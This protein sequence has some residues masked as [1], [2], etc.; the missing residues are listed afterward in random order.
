MMRWLATI[1]IFAI[2]S[3][4]LRAD[5]TVVQKTTVVGGIAAMAGGNASPTL[6]NRLKGM[7]LRTDVQVPATTVS[8]ITDLVAKEV[9]VLR[10]E[11]K[12]AQVTTAPAPTSTT[13]TTDGPAPRVEGSLTAT[14]KS[15]VIDGVKC[16]EYAFS[17]S[18]A[19]AELTGGQ[20]P[21]QAAQMFKDMTVVMKGSMWVA[22]DVPGAAEYVAFQK[23][24]A[25]SDLVSPSMKIAGI[26]VP[27]MDRMMKAMAGLD[28]ISYL[29]VMDIS[30]EGG[31]GQMS[32]LVR[33][34]AA[35]RITTRVTSITTDA[36]SDDLFKVP[37][38]YTI[39]K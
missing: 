1:V 38:G 28:G 33:Q 6:T 19:M 13:T 26:N 3:A 34:M 23:A 35:V 25:R 36:L 37:E 27:G 18:L 17:S 20:L 4:S 31:S 8:T 2:S 15:Q 22:R 21:P 7:K 30:M 39:T 14:G 10:A 24:M 16:E 12:I 11:Q 32:D 29:T 5:V 9:I